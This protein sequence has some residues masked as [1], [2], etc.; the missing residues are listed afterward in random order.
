VIGIY[1][2][3]NRPERL[4]L[5]MNLSNEAGEIVT[6]KA[7]GHDPEWKQTSTVT[8]SLTEIE[9]GKTK[10]VLHQNVSERLAKKTGAHPSWLQM[11]DRLETLLNHEV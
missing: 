10:L 7:A 6:A 8:L 4:V 2:G 9:K 3:V 5:T 1:L 11:L